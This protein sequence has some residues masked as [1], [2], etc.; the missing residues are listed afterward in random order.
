M[1]RGRTLRKSPV[2]NHKAA[3]QGL[4]YENLGFLARWLHDPAFLQYQRAQHAVNKEK[5]VVK[6]LAFTNYPEDPQ[7]LEPHHPTA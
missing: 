3:D 1:W 6:P 4:R 2:A 7:N 5:L